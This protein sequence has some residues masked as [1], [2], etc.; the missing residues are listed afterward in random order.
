MG[1]CKGI[2]DFETVKLG[3]RLGSRVNFGCGTTGLDV[4]AVVGR[5]KSTG[6]VGK[7]LGGVLGKFGID[8]GMV[9]IDLGIVGINLGMVG[10]DLGIFGIDLGIL[11]IFGGEILE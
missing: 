10:I 2:V 8:L 11:A 5:P 6:N 9:G 4:M 1:V 3:G 7:E